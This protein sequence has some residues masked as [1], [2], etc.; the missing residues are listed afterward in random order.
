MPPP[1][2]SRTVE[3]LEEMAAKPVQYLRDVLRA[4]PLLKKTRKLGDVFDHV[5]ELRV[6]NLIMFGKRR[7][8]RRVFVESEDTK[9]YRGVGWVLNDDMECC[10]ICSK[11][12]GMWSPQIHCRACGNIVC[13][14]CS[15][16][17]I[18]RELKKYGPVPVCACCSW[19]QELVEIIPSALPAFVE[20]PVPQGHIK[21]EVASLWHFGRVQ[22]AD[23]RPIYVLRTRRT[24]KTRVFFNVCSCE[25]VPLNLKGGLG[26]GMR[27]PLG[28]GGIVDAIRSPG[29]TVFYEEDEI[30]EPEQEIEEEPQEEHV[31]KPVVVLMEDGIEQEEEAEEE[32]VESE[33]SSMEELMD[34]A[35]QVGV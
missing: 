15:S 1:P 2:L 14:R 7:Q 22:Q 20:P 32:A 26:R 4:Q 25:A 31:T 13:G 6:E 28:C 27:L 11:G 18:V 19:E 16:S 29:D 17:N 21:Y 23:I 30:P 33:D 34:T 8:V 3:Y 9:N 35:A 5:E 24:D 12:F 10:M